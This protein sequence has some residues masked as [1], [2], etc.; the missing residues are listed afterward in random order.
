MTVSPSE[1]ARWTYSATFS[2]QAGRAEV[3]RAL[4]RTSSGSIVKVAGVMR[5]SY[6]QLHSQPSVSVHHQ[7]FLTTAVHASIPAN[8]S[9]SAS[10]ATSTIRSG[11]FA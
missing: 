1:A 6:L 4:A 10:A 3:S 11:R 5:A 8:T 7:V 9:S 2:S